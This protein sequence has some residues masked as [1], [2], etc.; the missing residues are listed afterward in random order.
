MEMKNAAIARLCVAGAIGAGAG[1][2]MGGRMVKTYDWRTEWFVP[3]SLPIVYEAMTSREAMRQWWPAMELVD[4][5][6]KD[7]LGVDS[8]VSFQVHQAP[9]IARLAPPFRIR[10]VYTDVEPELRLREVVT[11]DLSGVLETL[12][13]ED[14]EGP[15]TW[16]T[17]NWYVRV[18]NPLLNALGYLIE[19]VYRHSHDTVM[20]AGESGLSDYCTARIVAA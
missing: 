19:R 6:G 8:S 5:G 7:E 9:E 15:G 18:T 13:R 2:L 10:C 12:F 17:F 14:P 20:Q 16:V 4:E 1:L 11:G 3:A